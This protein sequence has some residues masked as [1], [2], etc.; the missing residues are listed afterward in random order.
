MARGA[1]LARTKRQQLRSRQIE[2]LSPRHKLELLLTYG[3]Y[4]PSTHNTQ[5]WKIK[6]L[7]DAKIEIH[8]DFSKQIPEA[9]P[10][11]RD[12]FMSLGALIKNIQLAAVEFGVDAHIVLAKPTL[13]DGL[14]ATMTFKG[15]ATAITPSKS[16]ILDA[17]VSR[18]NY[19]GTF[20]AELLDTKSI[21]SIINQASVGTVEA[22]LFTSKQARIKLA[23]LTVRGL[24]LAYAKPSFRREISS[25]I[26]H[27]LS[28]KR[29]GLHGYSL[30]MSLPVSVIV[31]KIMKRKDIGAKLAALN[32]ESFISA[33]GVV[34][35][36]C[37]DGP[38]HWLKCGMVLEDIM[39]RLEQQGIASSIYAAAIEMGDLRQQL[40]ESLGSELKQTPQLLF[41]IGK[42]SSPLPH[43]VR[44]E[45][46]DVLAK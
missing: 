25:F 43:S 23:D 26:N 11:F 8:A 38:S 5:P 27:N 35:L 14:A 36:A 40:R 24:R 12:L 28:R 4:A 39:L 6:I 21:E 19:R 44:K 17:I 37:Q 30:R 7:S 18:Q 46:R 33:P 22:K 20:Q 34:V 41:C 15:L 16:A 45:L 3:T 29:H 32:R 2:R 42:P 13:R 31:P 9:D 1:K 10:S